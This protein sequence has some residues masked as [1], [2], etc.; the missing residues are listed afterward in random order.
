MQL[1]FHLMWP[2]WFNFLANDFSVFKF[3]YIFLQCSILS[4]K[5][6][7]CLCMKK[8]NN[9]KKKKNLLLSYPIL[10]FEHVTPNTYIFCGLSVV[11]M[12]IENRRKWGKNVNLKT[13]ISRKQSTPN[14]PKN[15][16]SHFLP[17]DT[18][19]YVSVSG[20]KKCSFYGKF[21]VL[22]F[23]ET[24]AFS[25]FLLPTNCATK[26]TFSEIIIF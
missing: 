20:G 5:N 14:F 18:R 13:G 16:H 2:R 25:L 23:L 26:T 9:N 8:N 17:P 12:K 6:S 1:L 19:T 24:P 22:C 7:F 21:G 3:D 4:F 11:S 10:F 15:D